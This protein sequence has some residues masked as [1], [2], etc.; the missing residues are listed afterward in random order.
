M[1]TNVTHVFLDSGAW[2]GASYQ[3]F[4]ISWSYIFT[5]ALASYMYV[6]VY[7]CIYIYMMYAYVCV[8]KAMPS[9]NRSRQQTQGATLVTVQSCRTQINQRPRRSLVDRRAIRIQLRPGKIPAPNTHHTPHTTHHTPHVRTKYTCHTYSPVQ[10]CLPHHA[11]LN[12]RPPACM[13]AL[14]PV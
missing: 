10:H 8:F 3:L 12:T 13:H 7:L 14:Q 2:C 11:S 9:T 4:I 6:C 5:H 1:H